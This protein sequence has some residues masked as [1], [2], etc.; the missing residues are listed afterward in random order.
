MGGTMAL[1][2]EQINQAVD[3]VKQVRPA[4]TDILDF[5]GRLFI[6][7]E[8]SKASIAID[9]IN[10]TETA[11]DQKREAQFPLINISDFVID[12]AAS[13]PLFKQICRMAGEVSGTLSD[14][15]ETIMETID[16]EQ[17]ELPRLFSSFLSE[18]DA[19]LK[20]L[21]DGLKIDGEVLALFTYFSINPSI[22]LNTDQ[23][24]TFLDKKVSWE[25]GYCPIC[26]SLPGFALLE[27]EGKRS[28][29]CSFCRHQWLAPRRFCPFCEN[30]VEKTLAYFFS[31]E[32]KEYRV[33][34]CEKCHKYIKTL[35]MRNTERIIYVPLE[36]VATLHL[37][38]KAK[39]KGF[40]SGVALN[41]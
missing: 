3:K 36:Q 33:D 34:V 24:S 26:G 27:D 17:M 11:L 22:V 9:P 8:D 23:L 18:D 1:T 25:K 2:G 28:F 13:Q 15:A 5:Y 7:Q 32:E 35:D 19:Y 31:E 14:P 10:I 40:E 38:I 29:F 6:A 30:R 20:R 12:E 39:A 41:F 4:Y 21:A 37:D 16:N